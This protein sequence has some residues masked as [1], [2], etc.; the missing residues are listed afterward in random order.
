MALT[1]PN[2]IAAC[3]EDASIACT[4]EHGCP[5]IKTCQNRAWG[6][7]IGSST[8]NDPPAIALHYTTTGIGAGQEQHV[9]GVPWA[10]TTDNRPTY[11]FTQAQKYLTFNAVASDPIRGVKSTK[12]YGTLNVL[13]MKRRT[14]MQV[15]ESITTTS[16]PVLSE[17]SAATTSPS[18]SVALTV[19]FKSYL[20]EDRCPA[21]HLPYRLDLSL[22]A[23]TTDGANNTLRT[24]LRRYVFVQSFKVATFNIL[25]GKDTSGQNSI[26]RLGVFM[27]D[28]NDIDV[29]FLQE[30][31][32]DT[33]NQ[34][35]SRGFIKELSRNIRLSGNNDLAVLSRFPIIQ[36]VPVQ[37]SEPLEG[38]NHRWHYV[39]L[40]LGG[41]SVKVANLHLIATSVAVSRGIP[42]VPFRRQEVDEVM[43]HMR[44]PGMPAIILGDLNAMVFQDT[45]PFTNIRF[46][47]EPL[48]YTQ[49]GAAPYV[50]SCLGISCD[51][52]PD[53]HLRFYLDQI[54]VQD[55]LPGLGFVD[56]YTAYDQPLG[57]PGQ[58]SDHWMQVTRL[59]L[60]E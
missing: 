56:A 42:E 8:C 28:T 6:D 20:E 11:L 38:Y 9:E 37:F 35:V 32:Q 12:L 19:S 33:V 50:H 57:L 16:I 47:F 18:R 44:Y 52:T 24:P 29:A 55:S 15:R 34:L 5:G 39:I 41:F 60:K 3:P 49:P 51:M 45:P 2:A 53:M 7:C 10:G 31:H 26:D 25:N 13:C 22:T 58:L 59:H 30:A 40:G 54:W 1:A 17:N 36:N 23:E 27:H 46:E 21:D 48:Y 43:A 4:N 14:D